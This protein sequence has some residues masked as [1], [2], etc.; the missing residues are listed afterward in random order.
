[1]STVLG[2]DFDTRSVHAVL[3]ADDGHA[4]YLPV[5]IADKTSTFQAARN[6]RQALNQAMRDA[7]GIPGDPAGI[8]LGLDGWDGITAVGIEKPFT[9][10]RATVYSYGLIT[11]AILAT[12]PRD[13]ETY[14]LPVN[15][16]AQHGGWKALCGL[17]TNA[18]K[19]D[20]KDW[21]W[22]ELWAVHSGP[23]RERDTK[24]IAGW[25]Q[26]AFDAYCIARATRLIHERAEAAA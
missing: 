6:V 15:R 8:A 13:L 14:L 3:L 16:L 23:W 1:M 18:S 7:A 12:L 24:T 11:G 25:P 20:V 10:S 21:A 5:P 22:R 26:D 9:S 19:A 17:A 4:R 2:L